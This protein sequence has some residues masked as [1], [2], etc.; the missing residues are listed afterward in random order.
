MLTHSTLKEVLDYCQ[1]TGDFKYR[2]RS[3]SR[4]KIGEIAGYKHSEGYRIISVCNRRF[5]AHRLAWF[6][7]TGTW[8]DE[9]I[10]H[11]NM[12]RSDNRFLNL[13]LADRKL[14]ARNSKL[15]TRNK[16]GH[17]NVFWNSQFNKWKVKTVDGKFLHF[18]TLEDAVNC[19]KR[20]IHEDV[21]KACIKH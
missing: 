4:A 17:L 19:K 5:Y 18:S 20:D 7:V 9:L 12:D 16:S 13:R 6:Y 15:S 3:G 8:P 11:I 10:D 21:K 2:I 1:E 14:N